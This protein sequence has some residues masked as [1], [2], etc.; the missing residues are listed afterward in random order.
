MNKL[1]FVIRLASQGAGNA[2]ECNKGQWTNKVVDICEYL[3]LFNGL[4][5][6]DNIVTF[7]S[8][9]EGGCFLTQF[10]AISGRLGDF[11][12]GWIYIPN[13]I[14]I[15]GSDVLDAYNFVR[16]ILRESN[17]NDLKESI[18]DFF[19]KEY[20]LNNYSTQYAPSNGEKF[21]VRFIGYYTMKEILDDRYQSYYCDCKAISLVSLNIC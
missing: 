13:T 14:D 20:P 5:G 15:S 19:S 16:R 1:G 21:G 18:N 8:F 7:M 11:L 12:S 9:D 3:K 4:Q 17:L 10:R 6:T 2:I